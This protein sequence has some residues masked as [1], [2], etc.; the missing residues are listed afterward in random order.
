VLFSFCVCL[1]VTRADC[2]I[3]LL[4]IAADAAG[5]A[6]HYDVRLTVDLEKRAIHGREVIRFTDGQSLVDW[7]KQSGLQ[8]LSSQIGTHRMK[9]E[10][11]VAPTR[12]LRWLPNG[13]GLFAAF[14]CEA[15]MICAAAPDQ[16][17]SLRLEIVI[18]NGSA[19][20][21]GPGRLAK[22]WRDRQGRHFVFEVARPTQTY[23]F[24][25][26]VANL[27]KSAQ[28]NFVLYASGPGHSAALRRTADAAAFLREKATVDAV[29]GGY[30]QAFTPQAGLA[31]E[32]AG[33][34]LLSEAYLTKLEQDDDVVL[35]AHELAH[36]Y[37]G[38]LV[39]IRSWSDFW[40]NEGMAQFMSFAYL[41][42]VHGHA[43][44]V[45]RI[46]KV[47]L[48]ME[49]LR[50]KGLDRPL[51]FEGWKDVR[52]A[53]GTLP[54]VKGTL[55]LDRMRSELGDDVFWRGVGLYT[56]RSAHQL[57]DSRDFQR[58]FEEASGRDLSGF[59]K[60]VYG[61]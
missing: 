14:Y 55:F 48:E 52:D 54:Y 25:F 6:T 31:Q 46:E 50:G 23:L 40:L 17:A 38:V 1:I 53:L 30:V 28:G 27:V 41:E 12:G 13:D 3:L 4:L 49:E 42:R 7:Q 32:A 24:S 37:W 45:E 58:G 20:A 21:V 2:W 59:F 8:V 43:A 9:F 16:L 22:T 51:H 29:P 61:K 34:A 39:G 60:E 47:K 44:Y 35:M 56:S 26:C 36:Q 18:P 57:V 11:T 19:S 33:M 15:W 10:Y 5:S